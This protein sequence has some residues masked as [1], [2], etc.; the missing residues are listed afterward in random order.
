MN[1]FMFSVGIGIALPLLEQI[2][3]IVGAV[4]YSTLGL[5]IPAIIETVF[6][7]ENLGKYKWVFWKNLIIIVFGF[8]SLISGCT[9]TIMDILE[10]LHRKT[11]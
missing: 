11:E 8:G 4:F 6:R 3:N 2:I 9:V 1:E 7:W 5:I 10:I